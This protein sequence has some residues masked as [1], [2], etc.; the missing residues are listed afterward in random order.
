MPDISAAVKFFLD[1]AK[2][3][4]ILTRK[5]DSGLGGLG[6]TE[7]M[8]LYNL[9]QAKD[10]QM[11]RIDLAEKLGLT[12]S[13]IT[14]Q[15]APM[16]KIGLIERINIDTDAR[17]SL[18]RLSPGGRRKLAESLEDAEALSRDLLGAG[19]DKKLRDVCMLLQ[20][21]AK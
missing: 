14:R 7:F 2:T 17:V 18:T 10:G 11:R 20:T 9:S 8:I 5:F 13:C 15:L 1:L 19:Q 6:F 3:Q 4:A 16:E 12:A 21:I